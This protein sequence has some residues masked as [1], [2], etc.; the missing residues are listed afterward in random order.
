M[1]EDGGADRP[2]READ[3]IGGEGEQRRRQRIFIG[4]IKLAEHEAGRGAV[5][6]EIVPFD[7]GADS[8][9]NDRLAQ[10]GAVVGCRKAGIS[11]CGHRNLPRLFWSQP[12]RLGDRSLLRLRIRVPASRSKR[13]PR[14][15]SILSKDTP[16]EPQ[17]YRRD[18]R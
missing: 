17:W 12:D 13:P 4:E 5:K 10:L 2:R 18:P 16:A 15:A 8:R 9:G 3:E 14:P 11:G 7:G 6:K 1:A